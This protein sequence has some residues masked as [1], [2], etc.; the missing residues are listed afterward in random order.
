MNDEQLNK[1][2]QKKIKTKIAISNFE[3]REM[4]IVTKNKILKMVATFVLAIGITCGVV[5]AGIQITSL[6]KIKGMDDTGIQ[7]AIQN[8][9]VQ[10]VDMNYIEKE[11]VK[12]KVDY[13]MMDDINFDLVFNFIT[14]DSVDNYEGI[15]LQGLKITDENNNQIY[16]SSEDQNIWTKNVALMAEWWSVVE[17]QD[18]TL[19]QV[20]HFSSNNFPKSNKI[21]VKFENVILYNVNKG[22]PITI[23]YKDDYN[24]E[25]DVS[26]QLSERK[27]IEYIPKNQTNKF[28]EAKLTNSGFAITIKMSEFANQNEKFTVTDT[29]GKTYTLSNSGRI[30]DL[31]GLNSNEFMEPIKTVLIFNITKY[32]EC[33][34]ITLHQQDGKS[35]EF[36][37]A[38]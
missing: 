26:K 13:L 33:K 18:H 2:L 23:E 35:I 36:V 15:A 28:E 34:E 12:F 8:Q 20:V 17:K 37:R 32:N 7:T 3:E 38:K 5:Y 21:Y 6:F 16:I 11:K 24:L 14:E 31:D 10:N 22:N 4:N 25:F 9:Y 27:S 30:Y 1:K 29:E 19:R